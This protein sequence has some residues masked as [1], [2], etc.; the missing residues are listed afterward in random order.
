LSGPKTTSSEKLFVSPKDS[1]LRIWRLGGTRA[2]KLDLEVGW[3]YFWEKD[4]PA[5]IEEEV[6]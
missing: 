5:D 2:V 4:V 1:S 3:E 6:G